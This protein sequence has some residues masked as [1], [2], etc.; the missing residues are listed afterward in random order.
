[1]SLN[2]LEVVCEQYNGNYFG[3]VKNALLLK[4]YV[5]L[6]YVLGLF[7]FAPRIRGFASHSVPRK[8][9]GIHFD[10]NCEP[11]YKRPALSAERPS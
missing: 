9:S 6:R 1:M 7:F 11:Q 5:L 2:L 3:N 8:G 4:I 10:G